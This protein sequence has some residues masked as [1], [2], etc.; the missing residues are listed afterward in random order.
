MIYNTTSLFL[1]KLQI[2]S[3][4]LYISFKSRM[5]NLI[6]DEKFD[7]KLADIKKNSKG[8]FATILDI[9][10]WKVNFISLK[11]KYISTFELLFKGE[12]INENWY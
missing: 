2:S 12:N 7:D 4:F 3:R 5:D 10:D 6:K 1:L 9:H 8:M 11:A